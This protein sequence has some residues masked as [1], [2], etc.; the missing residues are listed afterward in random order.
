MIIIILIYV[1]YYDT[2][3]LH[4][5]HGIIHGASELG[6][7]CWKSPGKIILFGEHF[8]VKDKPALAAA[9]N[10][11][12][13]TLIGESDRG[14]ILE[15]PGLGLR[16]DLSGE[17][18]P[19]ELLP[20]RAAARIVD[21]R[22]GGLKPFHA[23]VRSGI[24]VAAGMGSSAATAASFTAALLD[25]CG[26]EPERGLVNEITYEAEKITHG[27]PSGIDNTLSVYGGVIRYE[28]GRVTRLNKSLPENIVLLA[29]DT[30]VPRNTGV[31]VKHVLERY[32]RHRGI[33][34]LIYDAAARLVDDAVEA[35]H[36]GDPWLIGE[37]ME[38]NHGLL[39]SIGVSIREIEELRYTLLD[40]GAYGAKLT[41]AGGGGLVIGL[42]PLGSLQKIY[43]GLRDKGYT[44]VYDLRIDRSG[45][46][47][48]PEGS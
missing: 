8:V 26:V 47:K 29:V 41:G 4:P 42:V 18:L 15:S 1:S 21:E 19:R 7:I 28:A 40:L 33:M 23:V 12:A 11:Y 10:L 45:I 13:E 37:L 44:K 36:R 25:Y 31:L 17:N 46:T 27:R 24:P 39:V 20:F 16:A 32:D 2:V 35:L 43:R 14:W 30:G 22:F 34:S 5:L 38:I 48:C 6:K 3:R 9:V